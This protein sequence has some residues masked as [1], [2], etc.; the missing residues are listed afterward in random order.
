[1]ATN[2]ATVLKNTNYS[3]ISVMPLRD[4]RLSL[5]SKGLFA[6][7]SAYGN[8]EICIDDI[9]NKFGSPIISSIKELATAGYISIENGDNNV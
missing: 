2:T 1:M 9:V 3:V 5:T 7:L 8:S 6:E 4:N